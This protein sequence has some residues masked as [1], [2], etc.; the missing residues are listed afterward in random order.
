MLAILQKLFKK[1][2]LFWIKMVLLTVL[3]GLMH[4]L[5]SLLYKEALLFLTKD[6]S[7][8]Q[9]F[10]VFLVMMIFVIGKNSL[11]YAF[12]VWQ[13]R[14]DQLWYKEN[15]HQLFHALWHR[16]E[17]PLIKDVGTVSLKIQ[18]GQQFPL[19]MIQV[20]SHTLL[21]TLLI[22]GTWGILYYFY[23]LLAC[24][25]MVLMGLFFYV[26]RYHQLSMEHWVKYIFYFLSKQHQIYLDVFQHQMQIQQF[27]F[28]KKMTSYFEKWTDLYLS[29]LTTYKKRH[30]AYRQWSEILFEI[31]LGC[32]LFMGGLYVLKEKLMLSDLI[33]I[34]MILSGQLSQMSQWMTLMQHLDELPVKFER[35]KALEHQSKEIGKHLEEP[36][37]SIVFDHVSFGYGYRLPVI[38]Q[39]TLS[40]HGPLW[41]KGDNGS[42]KST[43]MSLLI[44]P[45]RPYQGKIY[46][47]QQDITLYSKSSL[48]EHIL[49]I[50]EE[51]YLLEGTLKENILLEQNKEEQL[52]TLLK[53]FDL[54][55]LEQRLEEE[56][57]GQGALSL[58]Q[59][60]I[61]I[62]LRAMLQDKDV[63]ILDEA[64][65]HI[66]E[67]LAKKIP[68]RNF[69]TIP[70]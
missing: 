53:Q 30:I 26:L 25:Y 24:F 41:I 33:F 63:L 15:S 2:P 14:M 43:L 4:F 13:M 70:K 49:Y 57:H 45:H 47:N 5:N 21:Q 50:D 3:L 22:V 19:D 38:K 17:Y 10:I 34:Y 20:I 18:D 60:Q 68:E 7:Y 12:E 46:L 59:R 58:G 28:V 48:L 42:G 1:R 36:I 16:K 8:S 9:W 27:H 37:H 65:S 55:D 39:C 35:Y 31:F 54:V 23:P 44:H 52:H 69:K 51:S 29:H 6:P 40:I 66:E 56:I 11:N 67:K 61:I 62:L 32:F 64:M